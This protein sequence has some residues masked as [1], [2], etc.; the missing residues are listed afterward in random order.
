MEC[1]LCPNP[2]ECPHDTVNDLEGVPLTPI[3]KGPE[4]E[5]DED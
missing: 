5:Q 3:K 2:D 1:Q 4:E